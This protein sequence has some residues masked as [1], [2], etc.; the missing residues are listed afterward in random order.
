MSFK[1]ISAVAHTEGST[2]HF[3]LCTDETG[4]LHLCQ[5]TDAGAWDWSP[6]KAAG[7][8]EIAGFRHLGR[9]LAR[10][11]RGRA[12]FCEECGALLQGGA[13]VHFPGCVWVELIRAARRE[14][15]PDGG[16]T[17]GQ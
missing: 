10:N 7:E 6:I 1:L 11:P 8:N 4:K 14:S 2:A 5:S 17:D 12:T 15:T 16:A 9:R 13:T 3:G